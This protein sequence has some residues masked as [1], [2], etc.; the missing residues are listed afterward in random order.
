MA[1]I[2]WKYPIEEVHGALKKKVFG[3]AKRT[4]PNAEGE[5][6]NFSVLYGQ[7]TKE[8]SEAERSRWT[9]FGAIAAMVGARRKNVT[10]RVQDQVAFKAQSEYKTLTSYLWSICKAEYLASLED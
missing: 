3:A 7:R 4:S 6:A 2:I 8:V 9:K 10:K 5:Q 1:K